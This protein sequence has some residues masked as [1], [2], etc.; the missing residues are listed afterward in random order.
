MQ[1][2]THDVRHKGHT[3]NAARWVSSRRTNQAPLD[4]IARACLLA[5]FA[6]LLLGRKVGDPGIYVLTPRFV[7]RLFLIYKFHVLKLAS[8]AQQLDPAEARF[9]VRLLDRRKARSWSLDRWDI[10][11]LFILLGG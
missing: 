7:L 9:A 8:L 1:L 11:H 6:H 4:S 2:V 10:R 5:R 3:G